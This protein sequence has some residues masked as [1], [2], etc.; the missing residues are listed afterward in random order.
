MKK[1]ILFI[2]VV[3]NLLFALPSLAHEGPAFPILVDKQIGSTKVSIWTDPDTDKGT[4]DVFIEGEPSKNYQ[5]TLKASPAND[6]A[7]ILTTKALDLKKSDSRLD[8]R[9]VLPFDRELV[10]NVEFILKQNDGAENTITLPVE[11]TPPGPSR[12]EFALYFLP[13]LLVGFLWIKVMQAKRK[14]SP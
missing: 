13:F 4:F 10:W 6:P 2:A 14:I 8:F 7:H 9:A 5:I 12:L 11:V 3:L 1:N